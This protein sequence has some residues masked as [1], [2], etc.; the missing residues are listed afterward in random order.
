MSLII[1]RTTAP[2]GSITLK[3]PSFS[4]PT[5][6]SR[7]QPRAISAGGSIYVYTQGLTEQFQTYSFKNISNAKVKEL[8]QFVK[9]TLNGSANS[10]TFT[11]PLTGVVV[12]AYLQ[13]AEEVYEMVFDQRSGF[14]LEFRVITDLSV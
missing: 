6:I 3:D 2:T 8:M 7:R 1:E 11:N 12:T 14:E 10:C 9:N 13:N 5:R 4:F